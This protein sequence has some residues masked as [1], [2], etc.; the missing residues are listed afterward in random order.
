MKSA[1]RYL[2][3]FILIFINFLFTYKYSLRIT[4][5]AWLLSLGLAILQ[6]TVF[7]YQKRIC[8][9]DRNLKRTLWAIGA[10]WLILVVLSHFLISLKGLNVDRWSVISSFIEECLK[11][12]YPYYAKSHSGNYP[13]PMPFYFLL[14]SPFYFAGELSIFTYV[15][16]ALMLL[17]MI[18]KRKDLKQANFI[19]IYLLTC[20]FALWEI[21]TRSNIFTNATFILL[22]FLYTERFDFRFSWKFVIL[23]LMTG[24]LLST[25]SVF[26]LAYIIFFFSYLLN[27]KVK[28]S[29]LFLFL[30]IAV[31]GFSLTFLPLVS[32]F[33]EDFFRINPF[34]IE[35][36][37]LI[38]VE[39]TVLFMVISIGLSFMIK[40]SEDR[41]F[42]SGLSLFL[43]ILIY[44][45]Y[46]VIRAGF[47]T[48]YIDSLIDISYFILC[49]PFLLYYLFSSK[50]ITDPRGE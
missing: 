1:K 48:A 17:L 15:G 41:F 26:I 8:L 37:F 3:L 14:A 34:I 22:L 45:L 31:L 43:A 6:L 12:N 10:G 44:F 20:T 13:G 36:G 24:F 16:Y 2:S 50:A 23:A 5:W 47:Q 18:R 38:P 32:L 11:G 25:R 21:V 4:D 42:F 7:F 9:S 39:Y 40:Q 29:R 35:S 49:A 33:P 46:H 30:V 28:F 19:T 27:K